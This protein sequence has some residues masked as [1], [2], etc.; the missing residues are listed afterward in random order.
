MDIVFPLISVFFAF[1]YA[2][3][4]GIYWIFK[5]LIDLVKRIILSKVM[6][7]PK[8]TEEDYKAAENEMSTRTEKNAKVSKSG[9]VVRSLHHIDDEDFEDTAEKAKAFKEALA[10]QEEE[11]KK[12][13]EEAKKKSM[14]GAPKMKEDR[15]SEEKSEEKIDIKLDVPEESEETVDNE[16]DNGSDE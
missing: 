1:R 10:A 16:E 13:V 2:A 4:L 3:A 15:Q 5:S 9:R 7:L 6:P 11:D 14:F 12:N 8:F